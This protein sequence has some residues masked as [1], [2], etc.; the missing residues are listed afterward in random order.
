MN[1]Y[2]TKCDTEK[3]TSEYYKMTISKDGFQKWCKSCM[4]ENYEVNKN[5]RLSN[6]PSIIRDSKV[7]RDC[8]TRKPI[9][10]FHVKRGHSADGYGSYCKPCWVKR[11]VINQKNAIAKKAKR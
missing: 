4:L 2:C 7:C 3:N 8:N 1:K 10:Q 5:K 11:T 6:G 9:N